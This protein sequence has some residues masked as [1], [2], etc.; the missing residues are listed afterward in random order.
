MN[1]STNALSWKSSTITKN[2]TNNIANVMK[3]L[4]QQSLGFDKLQKNFI[5][6]NI[7]YKMLK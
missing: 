4:I 5:E 3:K 7:F 6:L 2:T 1:Q